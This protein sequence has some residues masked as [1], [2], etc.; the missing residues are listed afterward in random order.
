MPPKEGK[1]LGGRCRGGR[2]RGGERGRERERDRKLP[3]FSPPNQ[4][5]FVIY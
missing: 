2:C 4:I 5:T 1:V 3:H